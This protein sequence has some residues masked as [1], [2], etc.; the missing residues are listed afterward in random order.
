[1]ANEIL[2]YAEV[3]E[4]STFNVNPAPTQANTRS[5]YLDVTSISLDAPNE[6]D[7][8][9][10]S[11]FGRAPGRKYAGFYNPEGDIAYNIN[12]RSIPYFLKW[13]CGGYAYTAG[14]VGPPALPHGHESW[15]YDGRTLPS[16]LGRLGKD[17]FEHVF[18]GTT[19]D[20]LEFEVEDAL[21]TVTASCS[22]ARDSKGV[23]QTASSVLSKLPTEIEVPFH[24]VSVE[25]AGVEQTDKVKNLTL[26]I[27]NNADA[28][29]GRYLGRRFPGRIPVNERETTISMEMDFSDTAQIERLW[30]GASGPEASGAS[31]FGVVLS[32]FGGKDTEDND[33]TLTVELP[34]V[35]WQTV[36][37]Q[38][39]GR[40][41]T[42]QTVEG[43]G[44][45]TSKELVDGSTTVVTDV[46]TSVLSTGTAVQAAA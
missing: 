5:V 33:L 8:I 37:T 2:R 9:V 29:A 18:H 36:E 35:F 19:V 34:K 10:E 4:E 25:L 16:F 45:A 15:G 17:Q 14:D 20:S 3:V 43:R 26:S 12:V 27:A 38:P 46:Y 41:E 32:F 42:V 30:G 24:A 44:L 1:M 6:T 13:C 21:T 28:E 40:E 23:L 7:Q 39:E 22:A 31:T 11:A